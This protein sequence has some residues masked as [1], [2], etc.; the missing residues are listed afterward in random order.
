MPV[1]S[2]FPSLQP[3]AGQALSFTAP[4]FNSFKPFL[5]I[6]IG[7]FAGFLILN[8]IIA[9]FAGIKDRKLA[10]FQSERDVII[11][12]VKKVY[13]PVYTKQIS[14]F[15]EWKQRE[16]QL[17]HIAPSQLVDETQ[18]FLTKKQAFYELIDEAIKK[19]MK[20]EK[21]RKWKA[22]VKKIT[23]IFGKIFKA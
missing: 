4:L 13:E 7:F 21:K 17:G 18:E 8:V 14:E 16:F 22:K 12:I 9:I 10:E 20:E 5:T 23:G 11:N 3:I 15:I 19:T 1:P 2:L 6:I